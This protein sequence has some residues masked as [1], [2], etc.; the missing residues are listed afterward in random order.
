MITMKQ[1]TKFD[2]GTWK[3]ELRKISD[4]KPN[5]KNPRTITKDTIKPLR[6]SMRDNG[7]TDRIMID[8][9][10]MILSGHARWLV[11]KEEDPNAEIECLVAQRELTEEEKQRAIIGLNRD[12]G[13]DDITALQMDF[14]PVILAQ[15]DITVD[16]SDEYNT[17][18]IEEVEIPEDVETRVQPGEIWALGDHRLMCGD[19]T[20]QDDINKLMNG[21]KANMLLT[22]PP[23]NVDYEGS[24]GLKIQNDNM[25]DKN[26][27]EFLTKAFSI[28]ND[29]MKAGSAFYIWH[30]DLEGY[31]FRKAIIETGWKT[32]ECLQ[33]IKN[34][35]VLGRHDY[36]I[37]HEP[38]LYGWKDGASHT[39]NGGRKQTTAMEA[40]DLMNEEDLR[41]AYKE[42]VEQLDTSVIYENKPAKN[43]EHPTMKPIKL[44]ARLIRNSSDVGDIVADF[45]AGSGST[46]IA[47]EQTGRICYCNELD[48]AYCSV[49]LQRYINFTGKP[50][51]VFR[52]N[53]DGTKTPW[54][55]INA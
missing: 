39:W 34:S 42:L 48:P 45:F 49:I 43:K 52:L 35:L 40:I 41:K 55:E 44:M 1:T 31:N 3:T 17:K 46:L 7:Y 8:N 38:C 51:N 36:Q 28:A 21:E 13:I 6:Q 9:H 37:K 10:N 47:A 30:A 15:Y 33:W 16:K 19:S 5:P 54:S 2:D 29:N 11:F 27:Q 24:N 14:D 53:P 26:F 18:E 4:L 20:N 22:D 32:R 23:Y 12:G 50:E 25:E